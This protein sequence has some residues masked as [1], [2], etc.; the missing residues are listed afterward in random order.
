MFQKHYGNSCT[1]IR[2]VCFQGVPKGEIHSFRGTLF[3]YPRL[4]SSFMGI[5][6]KNTITQH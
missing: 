3:L 2:R 5:A 1:S 4:I 6:L